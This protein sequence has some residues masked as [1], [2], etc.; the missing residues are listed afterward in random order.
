[1]NYL[2]RRLFGQEWNEYALYCSRSEIHDPEFQIVST[3][4]KGNQIVCPLGF[5]Y[6]S[7]KLP[8]LCL[9]GTIYLVPDAG[10]THG[11]SSIKSLWVLSVIPG[12][13]SQQHQQLTINGQHPWTSLC[14]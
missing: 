5:N 9:T 3:E 7:P 6:N 13:S 14:F 10:I 8:V 12:P 11:N 1:M 4:A 2:N